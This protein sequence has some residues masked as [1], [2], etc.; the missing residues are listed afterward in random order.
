MTALTLG[1]LEV[2][3]LTDTLGSAFV[4][5][6]ANTSPNFLFI[7]GLVKTPHKVGAFH[8]LNKGSGRSG[9][10]VGNSGSRHIW[11]DR[12]LSLVLLALRG[13]YFWA[14]LHKVILTVSDIPYTGS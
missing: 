4:L 10:A 5:S 8:I 11:L 9:W 7:H 12:Y 2:F 13:A 1:Y 6:F 14:L 3:F